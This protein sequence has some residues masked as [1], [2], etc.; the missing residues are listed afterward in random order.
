MSDARIWTPTIGHTY[1]VRGY[2][3]GDFLARCEAISRVCGTRAVVTVLDTMRPRPRIS[4]RCAFPDCVREDWHGGDHEF[5]RIRI[6]ASLTIEV[7]HAWYVPAE[8]LPSDLEDVSNMDVWTAPSIR[9]S[10]PV[11]AL[12]TKG[13]ILSARRARCASLPPAAGGSLSSSSIR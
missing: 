8:L 3:T 7:P 6:G 12:M 10:T 13:K 9:C 2:H 1:I 4:D 11:S 5:A